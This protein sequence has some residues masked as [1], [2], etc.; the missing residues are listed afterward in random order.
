MQFLETALLF[1]LGYAV[2]QLIC[3]LYRMIPSSKGR[4]SGVGQAD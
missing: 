4:S 3:A 2:A 1:L